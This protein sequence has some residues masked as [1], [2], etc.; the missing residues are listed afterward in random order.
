ME[1]DTLYELNKAFAGIFDS[2]FTTLDCF[3]S[4]PDLRDE[5]D[6]DERQLLSSVRDALSRLGGNKK[7]Q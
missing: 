3:C 6:L 7:Q 1:S 2:M 5:E 4:D